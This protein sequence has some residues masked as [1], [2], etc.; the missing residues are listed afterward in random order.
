MDQDV[1]VATDESV[2]DD[3]SETNAH[4]DI[5]IIH[6]QQSAPHGTPHGRQ[7]QVPPRRLLSCRLQRLSHKREESYLSPLL[8]VHLDVISTTI[9]VSPQC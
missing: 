3:C 8:R 9:D 6:V 1:A 2:K 7:L 5:C 4:G